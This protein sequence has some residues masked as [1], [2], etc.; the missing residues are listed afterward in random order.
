MV[1]AILIMI[2]TVSVIY[3]VYQSLII[4]KLESDKYILIE[5]NFE[6]ELYNE[7]LQKQFKEVVDTNIVEVVKRTNKRKTD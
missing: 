2:L 4:S 5:E 3:N 1:V 7:E 6:L